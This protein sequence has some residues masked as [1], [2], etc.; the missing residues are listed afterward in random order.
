MADQVE[1]VRAGGKGI[2]FDFGILTHEWGFPLE[3][4]HTR[5]WLW[6]GA[7]DN[8]APLALARYTASHIPG[9]V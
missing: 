5:V 1:A 9:C 8:L 6:H 7:E 3:Q 2:T 4:I